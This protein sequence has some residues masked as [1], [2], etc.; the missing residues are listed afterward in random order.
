MDINF[1]CINNNQ[2]YIKFSNCVLNFFLICFFL[3]IFKT[4]PRKRSPNPV[5][6]SSEE[7]GGWKYESSCYHVVKDIKSWE[8][9]ER[10]CKYNYN[11]H[12]ITVLDTLVDTFLE[13]ILANANE[14]M[15]IGIKVKVSFLLL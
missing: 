12:L 15:W 4:D 5:Y 2:I 8:D 11:G 6:C 7:G 3:F 9:A 13:H 1:I 14:E 10:H